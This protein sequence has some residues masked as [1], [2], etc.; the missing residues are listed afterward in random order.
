MF[1]ALTNR[2][3]NFFLLKVV[4]KRTGQK[5][6]EFLPMLPHSLTFVLKKCFEGQKSALPKK[7]M[8]VVYMPSYLNWKPL[9]NR[10][11][12]IVRHCFYMWWDYIST[13]NS[14]DCHFRDIIAISL[15]KLC[16]ITD[17]L[18]FVIWD[19]GALFLSFSQSSLYIGTNVCWNVNL[20][21]GKKVKV[22]RNITY[23]P[24]QMDV[25]SI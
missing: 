13:V 11:Q 15:T 5:R 24:K 16:L 4:S 14:Y 2:M 8:C 23:D 9:K 1:W 21:S 17:L 25:L 12:C 22:F 6:Q 19:S 7:C 10:D 20:N 3:N 18:G